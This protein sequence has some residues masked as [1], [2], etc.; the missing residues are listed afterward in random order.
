MKSPSARTLGYWIA[1]SLVALDFLAGGIA[2]IAH[3]PM[4]L[5]GMQHLGYPAYFA[6]LLG[7]WKVLGALAIVA[8]RF[9]RLKEWAYAGIFF[10]LTGAAVS[11]SASG[12]GV[13]HA[14]APLVFALV[15]GASWAL[16]PPSRLLGR[17]GAAPYATARETAAA[18]QPSIA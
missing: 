7:A 3:P 17:L 14:A 13:G 6:S 9:P 5:A 10:D 15:A 2:A 1:T 16:R 8:P 4:V 18:A 11:H 12:D